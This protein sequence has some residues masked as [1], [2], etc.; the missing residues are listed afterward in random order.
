MSMYVSRTGLHG[1]HGRVNVHSKMGVS[2]NRAASRHGDMGIEALGG[3]L[4][5]E[6]RATACRAGEELRRPRMGHR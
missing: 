3:E 6:G 2:S 4:I 5:W 1:R